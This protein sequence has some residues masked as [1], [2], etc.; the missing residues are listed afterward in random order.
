MVLF[1]GLV[2]LCAA[3]ACQSGS[4][5]K[6]KAED[7]AAL[8]A[9]PADD[10]WAPKTAQVPVIEKPLLWAATRDG[11]TTYLFGTIHVGVNAD[12]QLP[13]WL[14]AKVDGARAFAMEAN[15][16]EPGLLGAFNRTDGGSL[17]L[18][19]GPEAWA[20]LEGVVG[21]DMAR[22]VDKLKPIAAMTMLEA[23][24]LPQTSAMDPALEGRAARAGKP[25]VYFESA[26]RQLEIVDPLITAADVKAFLDNLEYAKGKLIELR[27]A[28]LAGDAET[29]GKQFEDT[30]LW[31]AAGRDL[32]QFPGFVKALLENR[33]A[34]WIPQIEKL[35]AEGGGFVA[36]G[37]GHLAGPGNVLDM[38]RA[39]GFTITRVTGP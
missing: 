16:S 21:A 1:A 30:T 39:R 25:I 23:S 24:F 36:V 20:K 6:A 28:Y 11:T 35:H 2:A 26:L 5:A 8:V 38:L 17:R 18:D 14:K 13:A 19:L 27:D 31:V 15:L 37:A 12:T 29:L 10:P 9:A 32:A 3:G 4:K 33:N 22:G 7:A 34:A